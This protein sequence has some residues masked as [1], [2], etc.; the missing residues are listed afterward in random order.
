MFVYHVILHLLFNSELSCFGLFKFDIKQTHAYIKTYLLLYIISFTRLGGNKFMKKVLATTIVQYTWSPLKAHKLWKC[1][2]DLSSKGNMLRELQCFLNSSERLVWKEKNITRSGPTDIKKDKKIKNLFLLP[3]PLFSPI[4]LF[5][6]SSACGFG[7][8]RML[9]S[10]WPALSPSL[11]SL[12]FLSLFILLF[13]W[14]VVR[15]SDWSWWICDGACIPTPEYQAVGRGELCQRKKMTCGTG[16]QGWIDQ[17][18]PSEDGGLERARCA[19]ASKW[20]RPLK[21]QSE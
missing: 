17:R 8:R 18:R 15:H 7:P 5:L 3:L 21:S 19:A 9:T 1:I 6:S 13:P 14:A 4:P 10:H 16:R 2:V 11:L 20:T 12:T